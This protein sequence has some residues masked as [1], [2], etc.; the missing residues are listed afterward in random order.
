MRFTFPI[1]PFRSGRCPVVPATCS[2]TSSACPYSSFFIVFVFIHFYFPFLFST[3]VRAFS[4]ELLFRGDRHSVFILLSRGCDARCVL[5]SLRRSRQSSLVGSRPKTSARAL[6]GAHRT[7]NGATSRGSVRTPCA[8]HTDTALPPAGDR[9][10]GSRFQT[11]G[12]PGPVSGEAL[13][14][15]GRSRPF[16]TDNAYHT[17]AC[18]KMPR[19]AGFSLPRIDRR[20]HTCDHVHPEY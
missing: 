2:P 16:R 5:S 6:Y 20:T 13:P 7:N 10:N 4:A 1:F 8:P 11:L 3:L 9:A 12:A 14:G 15:R 18:V 17:E 19:R